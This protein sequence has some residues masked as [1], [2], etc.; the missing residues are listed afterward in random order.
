[1]RRIAL[2]GGMVIWGTVQPVQ[3]RKYERQN[4]DNDY[5]GVDDGDDDDDDDDVIHI[6]L[7]LS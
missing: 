1:M 5:D 4:D 3:A 6:P 7:I 2:F